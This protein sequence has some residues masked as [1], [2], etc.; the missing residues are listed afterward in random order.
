MYSWMRKKIY[1]ALATVLGI[2]LIC[3]G[4]YGFSLTMDTLLEYSMPITSLMFGY[5][6]LEFAITG[7]SRLNRFIRK[8]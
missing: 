7:K 3:F 4:L 2:G 8:S 1:R 5:F 6:M